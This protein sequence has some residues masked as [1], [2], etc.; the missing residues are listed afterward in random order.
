MN[1]IKEYFRQNN[2]SP[3]RPVL[4]AFVSILISLMCATGSSVKRYNSL[5]FDSKFIIEFICLFILCFSAVSI[6]FVLFDYAPEITSQ[7]KIKP[8]FVFLI[9]LF[10]L[11]IIY[12]IQFLGLYPGLFVFDAPTQCISY[13]N[14]NM[15]EHHP[16]LHTLLLGIIMDIFT[17][18]FTSIN[19]A[20][21]VYTILQI[22]LCSLSFSYLLTYLYVRSRSVVL[23]ILNLVYFGFCPPIV[24]IVMSATKDTFF[25]IFF[26]V[27]VVSL[28]FLFDSENK[29]N[30]VINTVILSLSVTLMT[31]FR[32]NC[33]YAL[34]FLLI[35]AL[36][37]YSKKRKNLLIVA[38]CFVLLFILYKAVF[39]PLT[40]SHKTDSRE[41]LS[42]PV[43]IAA[44]IYTDDNADISAEDRMIVEELIGEDGRIYIPTIADITKSTIN[45]EYLNTHKKDVIRMFA[46]IIRDNPH[47]A[48]D[49]FLCLNCGLW[50]PNYTLTLMPDGG[51]GYWPV[52][53]YYPASINPQIKFIYDYYVDFESKLASGS[54]VILSILFNPG[55]YLFFYLVMFSYTIEKKKK[56][57]IPVYIFTG[58][59]FLTFLLGPV[60]LVRYVIF[61]Y[62]LFPIYFVNMS[63]KADSV[64]DSTSSEK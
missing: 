46:H 64:S 33:I 48:L 37:V 52:T 38:G 3:L 16:L 14:H 59:Y 54:S 8:A 29:K 40:V 57:F 51:K 10:S 56:S 41:M 6:F 42:V 60:A 61:L 43:Q 9:A 2:I 15:S 5:V 58:V 26:I 30:T 24:L 49:A 7:K 35:P 55:L 27:S 31:L 47:T 21:A 45:T 28:L 12:F 39:V 18:D 13:F 23:F 25:M 44:R 19:H 4:T 62:V 50:Y 36:I 34:P 53:C 63:E 1:R 17:D 20:T 11:G 22:I 32:N